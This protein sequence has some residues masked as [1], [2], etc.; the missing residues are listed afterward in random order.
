MAW[1][2]ALTVGRLV[3]LV[4]FVTAVAMTGGYAQVALAR[5]I[6]VSPTILV[7][8]PEVFTIS[9]LGGCDE[10]V[11]TVKTNP[12]AASSLPLRTSGIVKIV[13][14]TGY[15]MDTK[16]MPSV[17]FSGVSQIQT[18]IRLCLPPPV[19]VVEPFAVDVT[20]FSSGCGNVANVCLVVQ[21]LTVVREAPSP[22]DPPGSV[23]ASALTSAA[24]VSWTSPARNGG[25]PITGYTVTASP[26]G[27]TCSTTG[28]LSCSVTGLTSE[29]AYT[30]TVTAT[31]AAGTSL[32][33]APTAAVTPTAPVTAP[34]VVTRLKAAPAK[35]SLRVTWSPPTNLGGATSVRYQYQ[36][37]K[38]AWRSISA[39]SVTVTGK[40]GVRI[41]VTVRAV[42]EAGFGPSLRV[43]GVPR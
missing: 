34:G 16:F 9:T 3:A 10:H 26:G 28:A 29:T 36:V 32:P 38:Q 43:S 15:A 13:D 7:D 35:G 21:R 30:F 14:Q 8:V 20:V 33:S 1:G 22:P 39:T 37:G 24:R 41:T 31:N 19:E 4:A 40:K 18:K 2:I 11:V 27:Q 12:N 23:T 6:S 17:D 25:A 5:E 42:N